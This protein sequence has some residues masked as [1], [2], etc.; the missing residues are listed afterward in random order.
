M[1]VKLDRALLENLFGKIDPTI[2]RDA[3]GSIFVRAG[4]NEA[5]ALA[6]L[7]K[8][9]RKLVL[10]QSGDINVADVRV[11]NDALIAAVDGGF[12]GRLVSLGELNVDAL[13]RLIGNDIGARYAMNNAL[14]FAMVGNANAYEPHN[15]DGSLNKFDPNTGERLMTDEYLRDRASYFAVR[16]AAGAGANAVDVEGSQSWTFDDRSANGSRLNASAASAERAGNRMTFGN[17]TEAGEMIAGGNGNDR[18]YGGGGDD[19]MRGGAGDDYI[20]GGRGNDYL[21]GGRG[22]DIL[23]GG[24]GEDELD[25]GFGND[26]LIGGS[27]A[28]DLTGGKGDDRMEG[29]AGFD[30]YNIESGDGVDTIVDSD[31]KGTV[32]LD[33]KAII[34]AKQYQG[35]D[36]KSD[37]GKTVFRFAGDP[38]EGG[39]LT[40]ITDGNTIK[41]HQF[42]NGMLGI[43]FGDGTAEAVATF[44]GGTSLPLPDPA[45][46]FD[47]YPTDLMDERYRTFARADRRPISAQPPRSAGQQENSIDGIAIGPITTG[48]AGTVVNGAAVT[49]T[50]DPVAALNGQAK[51]AVDLTDQSFVTQGRSLFGS[52]PDDLRFVTGTQVERAIS[53]AAPSRFAFGEAGGAEFGTAI[54]ASS[55]ALSPALAGEFRAPDAGIAMTGVS[56]ADIQSALADFHATGDTD[57]SNDQRATFDISL[58]DN[59]LAQL[60]GL[61]GAEGLSARVGTTLKPAQIGL[62]SVGIK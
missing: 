13:G 17:D 4:T 45:L 41:I 55:V 52:R 59:A 12:R 34:G 48:A 30:T 10:N 29:G 27:G 9:L 44:A 51:P 25:G 53:A 26:K 14:P 46:D 40:V 39:T 43:T 57:T 60:G 31:G 1:P 18:L 38:V 3:F 15:R 19:T 28:D 37:D 6:N 33:G 42:R 21:V 20:E 58:T 35:T 22:D 61:N 36:W 49:S 24:S 11:M 7:F 2:T 62:G 54:G 23:D 8:S 16:L 56:A 5:D 50:G 47:G 32:L